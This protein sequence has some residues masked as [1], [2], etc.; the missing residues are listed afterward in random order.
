MTAKLFKKLF[1]IFVFVF[2]LLIAPLD[3][4]A[5]TFYLSYTYP[6]SIGFFKLKERPKKAKVVVKAGNKEYIFP[7]LSKKAYFVIPYG[8][9]GKVFVTLYENGRKKDRRVIKVA[10]K[11]YRVSRIWVRE[12]KYTPEL[13]KRIKREQELLRNIFSQVTPK[14]FKETFLKRPLK[15]LR[16]STPFGAK[17]IING[18]KR[19]IH[20]GVDFKAPRGTPVYASLSGKVV[21][22]RNLFFTGNTVIIDH[23]LGIHTLYAHL[24][25]ITVKEGQFVKAGQL[26]GRVGSTGR[27]TGP[28]LHFGFYVN[29][30]RA[31]PMLVIKSHL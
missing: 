17:R 6:G 5:E 11:K 24:S 7:V 23:G 21:L 27:S 15:K 1:G 8:S 13:L 25:K 22:A 9:K 16:V 10:R 18:K 14:K 20:W 29:G 26:I 31:D 28:H 12:P 19:S 30:V 4:A 3:L 2:T